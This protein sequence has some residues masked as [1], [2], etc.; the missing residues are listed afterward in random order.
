MY[1]TSVCQAVRAEQRLL[2]HHMNTQG[3]GVL[4]SIF[5]WSVK[6]IAA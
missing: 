3:S 4:K 2:P 6:C 5:I 1:T